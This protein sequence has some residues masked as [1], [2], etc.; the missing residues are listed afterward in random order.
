MRAEGPSRDFSRS[1]LKL[2]HPPSA[3][4]YAAMSAPDP[5]RTRTSRYFMRDGIV[6][7]VI[8]TPGV[9]TLEDARENVRAFKA[10]A[11]G[12]R[13]PFLVDMRLSF[14]TERGVRAYYASEEALADCSAMA[15][16]VSSTPSRLVGNFFLAMDRPPVA[17]RMFGDEESGLLWLKSM[18]RG[19]DPTSSTAARRSV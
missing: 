9:H 3:Y 1:R 7:Q 10:L 15:M 5:I 8:V 18:T 16:I 19:L 13:V 2:R 6:R 4:R 14:S 11:G 12:G 17:C